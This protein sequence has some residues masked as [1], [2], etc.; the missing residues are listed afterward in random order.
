MLMLT[1]QIDACANPCSKI[2]H[3]RKRPIYGH[4]R[5]TI[6]SY[7][8]TNHSAIF[9]GR[10]HLLFGG[11]AL[12]IGRFLLISLGVLR[13]EAPLNSKFSRAFADHSRIRAFAYQKLERIQQ[14]GLTRASFARYHRHAA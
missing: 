3:A 5:T 14:S 4:A 13:E 11:S 1:A 9:R 12:L 10:G 2:L 8:T 7:P 6:E